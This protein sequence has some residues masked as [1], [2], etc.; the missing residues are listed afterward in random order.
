VAIDLILEL[1]VSI[2]FSFRNVTTNKLEREDE[3]GIL[4]KLNLNCSNQF[5]GTGSLA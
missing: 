2:S 1:D 4:P 5:I 3:V